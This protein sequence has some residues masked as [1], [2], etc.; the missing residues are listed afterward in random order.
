MAEPSADLQPGSAA[1]RQLARSVL[2]VLI[3]AA[4]TAVLGPLISYRSD[5][6]EL[7]AL[8][9]AR[10]TRDVRLYADALEHQISILQA[11]LIRLS[12]RPEVDLHDGSVGPERQLLSVTHRDSALFATGVAVV[13]ADGR[14]VWSEPHQIAALGQ[15]LGG[16]PWFQ[17]L[18]AIR[19]PVADVLEK[20]HSTLVVAV[21]VLR[22]G[23]ITG[24]LVGLVDGA[25]RALPSREALQNSELAL[26]DPDGDV[27]LPAPAA[28][29][30]LATDL[31]ERTARLL[32]LPDGMA[33]STQ[34]H[35]Y[36]GVA[37][38]VGTTGLRL[39]LVAPE[40]RLLMPMR[41]RFLLQLVLV[42]A[43]QVGAVLLI[44]LF[45]RR[46]YRRFLV[47]ERRAVRHDKLAALGAASSLI[48]HEVKNSLN[49]LNAAGSLL[50]AGGERTLPAQAL[51][52]QIDRLRHLAT[53]LLQFA[54]PAE[55]RCVPAN[56]E[57]L[58]RQAVE[59]LKDYLPEASEVAVELD[60]DAALE[61]PCDPLLLATAV[62]NLV[63]NAIEAAASSKDVGKTRDPRVRVTL[64]REGGDACITVE[65]NAGGP[66]AGFEGRLFEPFVTSKPKGIGLGLSMAK[67]AIDAQGGTL[68]F[69]RIEGGSRFAIRIPHPPPT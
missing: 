2:G 38:L 37:T 69:E 50:A 21:P 57:P 3:V 34:D 62:D 24:A 42:T 13:D 53:S 44:A 68:V 41:G 35:A 33:F 9:H 6:S 66:P 26:L 31:R 55:P 10:V 47:M 39:L 8:L 63:R 58:V 32:A 15:K 36:F 49:G 7:R 52:G 43:V 12:E 20:S 16:R 48:A 28:D 60:L 18:L 22:Q 65:D 61:V 25:S 11:E 56:L 29:G 30:S 54:R 45:V 14:L 51:K 64:H 4:A 1:E 46:T 67:Q 23:R 59:G 27:I 19:A 17:R 5:V 40:D